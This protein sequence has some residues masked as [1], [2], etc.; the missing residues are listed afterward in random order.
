MRYSL[1]VKMVGIS[2]VM[3]RAPNI[4]TAKKVAQVRR[5]NGNPDREQTVFQGNALGY[6][7]NREPIGYEKP[8]RIRKASGDDGAPGLWE[9]QK[10]TPAQPNAVRHC[11]I[12]FP[13]AQDH[14]ALRLGDARMIFRR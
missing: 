13:V 9:L 8:D 10:I 7:I 11:H 5:Y 1:F 4:T 12:L 2:N 3:P 14:R 6:K